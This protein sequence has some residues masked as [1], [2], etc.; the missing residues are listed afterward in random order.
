M[1]GYHQFRNTEQDLCN[2]KICKLSL[3]KDIKG[4]H[5]CGNGREL[6]IFHLSVA[7]AKF[8]FMSHPK[9]ILLMNTK[10]T[11]L[12]LVEIYQ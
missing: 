11:D 2:L 8:L 1:K 7:H 5:Q 9:D 4:F 10:I 6:Q 3:L 12:K